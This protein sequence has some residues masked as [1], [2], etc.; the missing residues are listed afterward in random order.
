MTNE[1]RHPINGRPARFRHHALHGVK[2]IGAFLVLAVL[3]LA[4]WN[5]F[6]PDMFGLDPIAM[7]QALGLAVFAGVLAALLR[8]AG[9]RP[10]CERASEG[11]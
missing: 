3:L 8:V 4:S 2:I 7:K 5:M 11:H 6:A 1:H 10:R 9:R